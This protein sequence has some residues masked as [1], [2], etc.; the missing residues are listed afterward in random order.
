MIGITSYGAYIPVWR[1]KR[2][3]I[4][5]GLSGAKAVANYDED[6]LTMAVA[7]SLDAMNGVERE[8]IDGV[9]FASTTSPYK[10]KQVSTTVSMACDLQPEIVTAD[11]ANSLRAG[12][13]ALRSAIDSVKAGSASQ[14]LVTAAD[15]RLGEP[16][17]EF[18]YNLGDG[19]AALTIGNTD[20][21]ASLEASYSV[22]DEITDVW[23]A[24]DDRFV[25]TWEER[26][27][28]TEGYLRVVRE[29]VSGLMQKTGLSTKDITKAIFGVP[30]AGTQVQLARSLGFDLKI[31]LQAPLT[32]VMG[33]TGAAYPLMLLVA[34][35]EESKPGDCI[36]LASYGNGSDAFIFQVTEQ[37][38]KAK[39][40]K[41]GMQGYLA[42]K[43]DTDYKTYLQRKGF[44]KPQPFRRSYR[45]IVSMSA[46]WR[47][48]DR[49]LRLH[50]SACRACGTIQYPPQR[51]C[52]KC[53]AMDQ[54]DPYRFSD[55]RAKVYTYTFDSLTN[56]LDV[57]LVQTIIDFDEG[58]RMDVTMTD[59]IVE[60]VKVG[61]PVEMTFRKIFID[62]AHNYGW[63]AMPPRLETTD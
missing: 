14:I 6:S 39:S 17:S 50:G 13:A 52:T 46:Y 12:T 27:V 3:A 57:P 29:A 19:A 26:F 4:A 24:E 21:A 49:I 48:R 20:V 8:C 60:E 9:F 47:E 31:Q 36:L 53:H 34:A 22:A 54:S 56:P 51:V 63:K 16:G 30:N 62:G 25:Q 11:F 58:G 37:I 18:E 55:K 59:R 38:G 41:R 1:L 5:A 23:R 33:Y 35:L 43:L 44:I 2:E 10:E 61:M 42:S 7:A 45:G 28:Y 15:C 32:D 40:G